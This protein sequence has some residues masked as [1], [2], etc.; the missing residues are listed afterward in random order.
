MTRKIIHIDMD[1]YYASIEQRDNPEFK[2]RPL[3]VGGKAEERGVVSAA[4]YEARKFGIHSAMPT[5][6]AVKLCKD[7]II[8]RPDFSKYTAVAR[9]L[10]NIYKDYT[11]LIEPMS[12]DEAY[13]DVT[14]NK[15]NIPTATEI[16]VEIKKRI[17][18]E[19][20]LTASAGV[21]TNK[22]LAKIASDEKKPDGLFVIK[23]HHV[24]HFVKGLKVGK[25]SG[26]G[27]VT[28]KRMHDMK[29]FT[30]IDLQKFAKDELSQRFG[31]FGDMLYGFC[32]GI[33][34][35]PVI[36]QRELKSIGA[37]TTFREDYDDIEII[38][39]A[40]LKQTE[41][42]FERLSKQNV[43]CSTIT[44]KLKYSDF[45]QIT[46]SLTVDEPVCDL[47]EIYKTARI[48]LEKTEA[49]S[50]KVRLV[51]VSVGN[52]DEERKQS[53]ELLFE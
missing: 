38:K 46:R 28:E 17:K 36:T 37:E 14:Q 48:L 41:R 27:K 11:D 24:E 25:I 40:L 35:R 26:V 47:E 34:N 7:L 22:M 33:D 51:G 43:K 20:N 12:L 50:R 52:F 49:G 21:A 31:K 23:P 39:N 3:I 9:Y 13:L 6:T 2:G 18:E 53:G 5:R 32:R 29:I 19:L 8:V 30:C 1:A 4:S 45:S 16:A 15:K 10:Y 42:V 44:I